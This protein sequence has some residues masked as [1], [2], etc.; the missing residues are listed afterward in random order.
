MFLCILVNAS[1]S[2]MCVAMNQICCNPLSS[3]RTGVT[4]QELD[5]KTCVMWSCRLRWGIL[6]SQ[7]FHVFFQSRASHPTPSRWEQRR[8]ADGFCFEAWRNEGSQCTIP[9]IGVVSTI[10]MPS[11][12]RFMRMLLVAMKIWQ[13]CLV[14]VIQPR[15]WRIFRPPRAAIPLG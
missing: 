7:I 2:E 10:S 4:F 14:Y 13:F 12:L 1:I 15:C 6:N 5:R 9:W 11:I 8:M 3:C